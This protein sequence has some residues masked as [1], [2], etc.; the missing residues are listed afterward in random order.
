MSVVSHQVMIDRHGGS[1]S[2][3]CCVHD[4]F[5]TVCAVASGKPLVAAGE[6]VCVHT[7][8]TLVDTDPR[9]AGEHGRKFGLTNC[10]Q[11]KNGEFNIVQAFASQKPVE[12]KEEEFHLDLKSI[13]L[14]NI[15]ITKINEENLITVEFFVNKALSKF[16]ISPDQIKVSVDSKFLVNVITDKDTTFFKH[17]HVDLNVELYIDK[18]QDKLFIQPSEFDLEHAEFDFEGSIDFKSR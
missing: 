12:N 1:L 10:N 5:T 18:K 8:A 13:Q 3:G 2:F 6:S 9:E 4:F 11:H 17:K 16:K 14:E 15:D 7:N